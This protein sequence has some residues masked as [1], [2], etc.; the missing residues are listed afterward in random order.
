[1]GIKGNWGDPA[2]E[3]VDALDEN[4]KAEHPK[5][6][7]A[8]KEEKSREWCADLDI[9]ALNSILQAFVANSRMKQQRELIKAT[10]DLAELFGPD[11]CEA[12]IA[13]RKLS[14]FLQEEMDQV[15]ALVESN[16]CQNARG[17][18]DEITQ[19]KCE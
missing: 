12:Q 5:G 1:M 8:A 16:E 14:K 15:E 11:S 4:I 3:D 10:K 7:K 9:N 13:K 19:D 18:E 17:G 2:T 6:N